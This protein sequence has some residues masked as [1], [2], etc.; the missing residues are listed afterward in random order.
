MT[1]INA[2]DGN[3]NA[4][5]YKVRAYNQSLA[6]RI[7]KRAH[8]TEQGVAVAFTFNNLS[9]MIIIG[10]LEDITRFI[11]SVGGLLDLILGL[12]TFYFH[13]IVLVTDQNVYIYRDWPLHIPGKLLASYSRH[14]EVVRLGSSRQSTWSKFIRRGQLT[15]EDG[16]IVY[17]GFIWIRRAQYIEQE[18]NI[19]PGSNKL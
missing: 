13:R 7:A 8:L 12:V 15:F 3:E 5:R 18:A 11:P 19:L 16:F 9:T 10:T 1:D 14:P 2:S 4:R 17:H 6:Q